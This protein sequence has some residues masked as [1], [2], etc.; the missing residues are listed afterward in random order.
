LRADNIKNYTRG[1]F[2]GNFEPSL[3]RTKDFEVGVLTHL[4]DEEWPRHL[5]KEATEYNYIIK[6]RMKVNDLEFK[7]GDIFVIE[8]N[9]LA[10]PTFLE[11]CT[12]LVIKTPS[13][14]GDKYEV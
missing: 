4:K 3:L 10:K 12:I 1:W 13:V 14:I 2:I 9:E 6:G 5:H 7:E 8:K 11:D